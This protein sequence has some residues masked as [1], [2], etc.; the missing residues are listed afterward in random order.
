MMNIGATS[1]KITIF[2]EYF[3]LSFVKYIKLPFKTEQ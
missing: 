1:K 2:F 3:A